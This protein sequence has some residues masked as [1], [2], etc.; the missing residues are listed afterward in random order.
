MVRELLIFVESRNRKPKA[1]TQEPKH[2]NAK[3]RIEGEASK[4]PEW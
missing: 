2:Y 3:P 1:P 4:R